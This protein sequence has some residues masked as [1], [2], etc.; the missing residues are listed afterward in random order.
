MTNPSARN[1]ALD[2]WR[3][4]NHGMLLAGIL[5]AMSVAT[6][7]AMPMW[8]GP[9]TGTVMLVEPLPVAPEADAHATLPGVEIASRVTFAGGV[10]RQVAPLEGVD[11]TWLEGLVTARPTFAGVPH[12][13]A[14]LEGVD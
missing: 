7:A 11:G 3:A 1:T 5:L 12:Q 6:A 14:P 2:P 4:L 13:V 10:P 9:A 8:P